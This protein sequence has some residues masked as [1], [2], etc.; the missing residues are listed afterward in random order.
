MPYYSFIKLEPHLKQ[1]LAVLGDGIPHLKQMLDIP[2]NANILAPP[3]FNSV[4][5]HTNASN[6]SGLSA[7][8]GVHSHI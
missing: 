4:I 1:I 7:E 5:A 2:A 6:L 3:E 8:V